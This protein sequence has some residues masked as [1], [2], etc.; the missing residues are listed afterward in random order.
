MIS[1]EILSSIEC[2]A[3]NDVAGFKKNINDE[4]IKKLEDLTSQVLKYK[5]KSVFESD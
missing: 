5:M 4:L 1:N 3:E 2:A